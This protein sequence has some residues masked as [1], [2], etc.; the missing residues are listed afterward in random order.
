MA[1]KSGVSGSVRRRIFARDGYSCKLCG[2]T[3][4][5]HRWPSGSFTYPTTRPGVFLSIDHIVAKSRGG[6]H[7]EANLRTLCTTC[8]TQKGVRNA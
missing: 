4:C 2:L 5:E 1:M 3:G 6:S 8:N 7:E